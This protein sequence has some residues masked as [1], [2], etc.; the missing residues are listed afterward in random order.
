MVT[1]TH[2]I[3]GINQPPRNILTKDI[4]LYTQEF[5]ICWTN[6]KLKIILY[7]WITCICLFPLHV[8]LYL[9]KKLKI[10]VV[11]RHKGKRVPKIVQQYE[12]YSD[13]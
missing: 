10:H 7:L 11:T 6:S 13:K 5:D 2:F 9:V 12:A 4:H 1:L 8:K 3:S